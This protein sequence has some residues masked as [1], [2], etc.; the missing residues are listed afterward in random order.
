MSG[1]LVGAAGVF[2]VSRIPVHGTYLANVLPGLVVMAF[3][4]GAIFVGVQ[5][6]ANAG[7]PA[8]KAGLAAALASASAQL[9][10]AL[11][12]AVFT[13]IA[14][15]H[16]QH[17]LGEHV[18]RSAALTSGCQHALVACSIFLVVAAAIATRAA[19]SRHQ[20]APIVEA[21]PEPVALV[22]AA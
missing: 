11:G 20:A 18:G 16:T 7:V 6:A 21:V 17:L 5:T 22:D 14:A 3:G 9:G 13:A 12:L 4:L 10:S 15:S 2:W 8:D 1:A 19:N